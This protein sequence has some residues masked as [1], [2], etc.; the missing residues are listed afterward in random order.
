MIAYFPT[1]PLINSIDNEKYTKKIITGKAQ[2]F[3]VF[4]DYGMNLPLARQR[5]GLA[6]KI[7]GDQ[8]CFC[9]AY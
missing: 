5:K 8:F 4:A 6:V 2:E 3:L 9:F 7:I 1:K